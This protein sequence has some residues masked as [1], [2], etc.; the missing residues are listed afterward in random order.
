M[1]FSPV[2]GY[3]SRAVQVCTPVGASLVA[4][5]GTRASAVVACG[6]SSFGSQV[7]ERRLNSSGVQA[8]L[9]CCMWDP[10]R[11]GIKRLPPALALSH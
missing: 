3:S 10:P 8:L 7:P 4:S 11:P 2:S 1:D 5:T 6:L 9:L